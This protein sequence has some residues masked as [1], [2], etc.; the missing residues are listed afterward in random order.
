MS[1]NKNGYVYETSSMTNGLSLSFLFN[2]FIFFVF[3]PVLSVAGGFLYFYQRFIS[4]I[5]LSIHVPGYAYFII[6]IPL[7]YS[8]TQSTRYLPTP[9]LQPEFNDHRA[10]G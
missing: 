7:R 10:F 2:L 6:T 1:M 9:N 8:P 5:F 3:S 4:C